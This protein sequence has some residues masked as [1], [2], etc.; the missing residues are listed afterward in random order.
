MTQQMP[1]WDQAAHLA[2]LARCT[3]PDEI[4]DLAIT[5]V[6]LQLI[7]NSHS[8]RHIHLTLSLSDFHFYRSIVIHDKKNYEVMESSKSISV[9]L[10]LETL[11][12]NY[13]RLSAE[14][15]FRCN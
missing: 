2:L 1:E 9:H 7:S 6:L 11:T 4:L 8:S 5:R 15:S 3:Y 13:E 10:S 14:E 12:E